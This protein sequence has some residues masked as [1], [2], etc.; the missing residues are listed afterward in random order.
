VALSSTEAE[1]IA[2]THPTKKVIWGRFLLGEI[3]DSQ[4]KKLPLITSFADNQ[5]CI[6][7]VHNPECLARTK[8]IDI[9]HHFVREMVE[10]GEVSLQYTPTAV[11]IADCLTKYLPREQLVQHRASMGIY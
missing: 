5:E 3:L 4:F 9:Q 8:N 11:I 1:Y 7:L 6:A 10:G 2:L